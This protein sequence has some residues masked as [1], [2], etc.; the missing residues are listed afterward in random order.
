MY[1]MFHL[2]LF[3]CWMLTVSGGARGRFECLN[4]PTS[5][6]GAKIIIEKCN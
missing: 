3:L 6:N 5:K 2:K 1:V 4:T